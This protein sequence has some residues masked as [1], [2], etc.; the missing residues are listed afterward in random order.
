MDADTPQAVLD[1]LAASG[2][3]L[4]VRGGKLFYRPADKVS[5][6]LLE[7]LRQHKA[8]L[9]TAVKRS[10][11]VDT[12]GVGSMYTVKELAVLKHAGLSPIDTPAITSLKVVFGKDNP[13]RVTAYKPQ[14]N[15]TS[16]GDGD[17]T[18]PAPH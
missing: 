3:E 2:V 9:I 4:R 15:E 10:G 12:Q 5:G 1:D 18:P 17:K 6:D 13:V 8:G 14:T 11:S 16:G 7:R